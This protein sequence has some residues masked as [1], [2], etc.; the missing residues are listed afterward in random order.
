MIQLNEDWMNL[1]LN[2]PVA[3]LKSVSH[4]AQPQAPFLALLILCRRLNRCWVWGGAD[5]AW[6]K[7][8]RQNATQSWNA[9]VHK[10]NCVLRSH[11]HKRWAQ[12]FT[13]CIRLSE[14]QLRQLSAWG[15]VPTGCTA[16]QNSTGCTAVRYRVPYRARYLTKLSKF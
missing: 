13:K 4:K 6:I 16:V 8:H 7:V 14:S 1:L 10:I 15:T 5:H 12:T 9:M 11:R 3:Q 2:R